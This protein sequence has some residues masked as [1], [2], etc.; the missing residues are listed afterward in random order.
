LGAQPTLNNY[1]SGDIAEVKIYDAA[2]SD[3]DR[4][5]EESTLNC[6][7]ALG[8]GAP[9]SVPL[10]LAATAGNRQVLLSWKPTIGAS[11]YRINRSTNIG[12]PYGLVAS[13]ITATNY[14]DTSAVNG[15]TNYYTL[16]AVS[17]CGSSA[18]SAAVG[19]F[20][21]L[22]ALGVS[23]GAGSLTVTW[24]GWA[25]AMNLYSAT[26]LVPPVTWMIVTNT[27]VAS[28][29]SVTL[30]IPAT[31]GSRFYRLQSQ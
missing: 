9:P 18:N 24:P 29:N 5:A 11:S 13:G 4:I 17:P 2:L 1:L 25:A 3:S 16:A 15:L 22:P 31:N 8:A 20:L 27:P 14:L 23:L 6:K 19:V 30:S 10:G 7:Y 26:N 28:S 21:P 12:G